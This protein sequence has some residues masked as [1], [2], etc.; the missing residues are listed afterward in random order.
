MKQTIYRKI[1]LYL[2]IAVVAAVA[3]LAVIA[4][5]SPKVA[6]EKRADDQRV[7]QLINVYS[8]IE[9]YYNLNDELPESLDQL[10]PLP[11]SGDPN[12][13]LETIEYN[14]KEK[15]QDAGQTFELCT[16]FNHE[17]KVSNR[18]E[19]DSFSP[20]SYFNDHPAGYHC[21]HLSEAGFGKAII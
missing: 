3:V 20:Y 5:D 16:E 10:S 15:I 4:L 12:E 13:S 14:L 1:F 21:F 17:N 18:T 2:S 11:H 8:R 9:Q 7:S 19:F 6:R